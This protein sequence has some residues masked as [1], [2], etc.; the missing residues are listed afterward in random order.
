MWGIEPG[1]VSWYVNAKR[2]LFSPGGSHVQFKLEICTVYQP[3]ECRKISQDPCG[4]FE[5]REATIYA[6]HFSSEGNQQ[7]SM[8]LE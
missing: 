5:N 4:H 1:K 6:L 8:F 2:A 3:S 7:I